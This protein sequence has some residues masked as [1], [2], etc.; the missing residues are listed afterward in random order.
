MG[1]F[2]HIKKFFFN[3]L[4]SIVSSKV[5]EKTEKPTSLESVNPTVEKRPE[6]PN[7]V[8]PERRV[9]SATPVVEGEKVHMEENIN[10]SGNNGTY[11]HL[12]VS[13]D[14]KIRASIGSNYIQNMVSNGSFKKSIG[15]V[16]DRRFYFKGQSLDTKG[17]KVNEEGIVAL[18]DIAFTK[19]TTI[20]NLGFVVAALICAVAYIFLLLT[21]LNMFPLIIVSVVFFI[22]S[23]IKRE[24]IF[25]VSFNGGCF[26]FDVS[27]YPVAEFR[28]FQKQLHI[29][30]DAI[31]KSKVTL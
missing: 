25:S 5:F 15:I 28:E 6:A 21:E 30:K 19:F 16:T 10:N 8:E 18:S 9:E 11:S 13:P 3:I 20:G 27:Q 24:T 22:L 17:K 7:R 4:Y 26:N 14:E 1:I 31:E 29:A 12:F 2:E 23:I